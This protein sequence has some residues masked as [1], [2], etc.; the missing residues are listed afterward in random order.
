MSPN[1]TAPAASEDARLAEIRKM[2]EPGDP[3]DCPTCF[4]L[5]LLDAKPQGEFVTRAAFDRA[6]EIKSRAADRYLP[7][8][9]CRDKVK[10]GECERCARQVAEAANANLSAALSAAEGRNIVLQQSEARAVRSLFNLYNMFGMTRFEVDG[11]DPP[12]LKDGIIDQRMREAAEIL[13][14]HPALRPAAAAEE[15]TANGL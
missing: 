11:G 14:D 12:V 1:P 13:H 3:G 10:A 8:P 4:V 9:D 7:C 6:M 15:E 5:R 2:H